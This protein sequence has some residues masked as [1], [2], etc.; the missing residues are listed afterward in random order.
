MGFSVWCFLGKMWKL[1]F[2][3]E[4]PPQQDS[5]ACYT[6][7]SASEGHCQ[8]SKAPHFDVAV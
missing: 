1:V 5:S 8:T 7:R 3:F 4:I 6:G 2:T